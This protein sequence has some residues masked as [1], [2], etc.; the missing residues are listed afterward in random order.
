[1]QFRALRILH[2]GPD[3][4]RTRE[5]S[6]RADKIVRAACT[7]NGIVVRPPKSGEKP[8]IEFVYEGD[9]RFPEDAIVVDVSGRPSEA[10]KYSFSTAGSPEFLDIAVAFAAPPKDARAKIHS[11][12]GDS[13]TWGVICADSFEKDF[14]GSDVIGH[15]ITE[16]EFFAEPE[17]I[18]RAVSHVLLCPDQPGPMLCERLAAYQ[19]AYPF[20]LGASSNYVDPS[21]SPICSS[22]D[23]FLS[24]CETVA[25]SPGGS[26]GAFERNV[27]SR[28]FSIDVASARRA[29]ATLGS[30]LRAKFGDDFCLLNTSLADRRVA[31]HIERTKKNAS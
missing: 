2:T 19:C 17:R 30:A 20:Y 18:F 29:R 28:T 6:K 9:A 24:K 4:D 10:S 26:R 21:Y 16:S 11:L 27:I 22:L 1:M 31:E 7:G 12:D 5:F 13:F 8:H 15:V 25:G 14:L 3:T 23:D